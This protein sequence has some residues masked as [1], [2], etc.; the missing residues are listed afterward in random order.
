MRRLLVPLLLAAVVFP[1]ATFGAG[2]A[3]DGSLAVRDGHGKIVLVVRGSLIG[4]FG[5]GSLTIEELSGGDGTE[6][7]VRG[8]KSFKWSKGGNARTYSGKGVRFRLI[9][10]RYVLRISGKGIDLSAVGTATILIKG[11]DGTFALNGESPRLLPLEWRR[12]RLA[13]PSTP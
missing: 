10:G 2:E 11:T 13:A 12:F 1:A 7:V 4:R 9:G 3:A 5:A 6:P 8:Y